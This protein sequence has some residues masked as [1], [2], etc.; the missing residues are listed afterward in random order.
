MFSCEYCK[1]LK[2]T[3]FEEHLR[4]AALYARCW[5]YSHYRYFQSFTNAFSFFFLITALVTEIS[6]ITKFTFVTDIAHITDIHITGITRVNVIVIITK[7]TYFWK[8][9][10]YYYWHYPHHWHNTGITYLFVNLYYPYYEACSYYGNFPC[11]RDYRNCLH[12]SE[13][14]HSF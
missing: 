7:K 5:Y 14:S 4:T 3:Y 12:C 8:Y 11:S 1:I 10:H 2:N 13:F 9:S 6:L